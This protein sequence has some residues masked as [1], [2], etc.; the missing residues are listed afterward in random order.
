MLVMTLSE[1]EYLEI[2]NGIRVYFQRH[3]EEDA[4]SVAIDAPA[5]NKILR[6]KLY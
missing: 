1:D 6:G 4:L 2:G 3:K 5:D